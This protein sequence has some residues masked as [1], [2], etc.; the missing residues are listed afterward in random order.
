MG[1]WN[2]KDFS[3]LWCWWRT[4]RTIVF[5]QYDWMPR[6]W[7]LGNF[8]NLTYLSG[9]SSIQSIIELVGLFIPLKAIYIPGIWAIYTAN[10]V[11]ICCLPPFTKTYLNHHIAMKCNAICGMLQHSGWTNPEFSHIAH[12]FKGFIRFG[13]FESRVNYHFA[14]SISARKIDV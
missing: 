2:L 11:I 10:W 3:V 7:G 1:A 5:W 8:S 13:S 14:G 9:L 12:W 6:S 4:F